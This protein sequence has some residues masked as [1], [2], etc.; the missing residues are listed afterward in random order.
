MPKNSK[1]IAVI[2]GSG[3]EK[4]YFLKNYTNQSFKTPFGTVNYFSGEIESSKI[5]FISRHEDGH[6]VPPHLVNYKANIYALKKLGADL[7]ISTA[8]V[9][10][11]DTKIKP[12][13]IVLLSDF[14]DF[15]KSRQ[16]TFSG[17]GNCFHIDMS[18]PYDEKLNSILS[19]AV[20]KVTG[21]EP[22]RVVY[23]ATEGP[24]FET[25]SE[26]KA[27]KKLGAQVVG[28]TNVPEVVLA[29][30]LKISYATIGIVTNYA[31]GISNKPVN[32]S[33]I[34][35]SIQ[36]SRTKIS[37]IITRTLSVII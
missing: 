18:C 34:E 10:S 15:T 17:S 32:N 7:I 27:F 11:H 24:R 30:E 1:I 14:I 8:A 13:N 37:D 20:K 36:R 12:G 26:I 19:K 3:Y 28:M 5:L 23:A 35:S 25:K 33:D 4:P 29:N 2:G 22:K 21:S 6:K 16:C 31:C 9:G